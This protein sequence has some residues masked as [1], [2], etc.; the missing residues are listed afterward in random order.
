LKR[1]DDWVRHLSD[2]DKCHLIL[3]EGSDAWLPHHPESLSGYAG[4]DAKA[5]LRMLKALSQNPVA[6]GSRPSLMQ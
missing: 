2:A 1:T 5:G 4:E 3:H 6:H